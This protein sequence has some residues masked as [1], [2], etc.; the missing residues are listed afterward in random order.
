MNK[1]R[2]AWPFFLSLMVCSAQATQFIYVNQN[3]PA[4]SARNGASWGNAYW[5]LRDALGSP[6]AATASVNNPVEIWV[7]TGTYKPTSDT[8][9]SKSFAVPS[10]V[11]IRGGFAGTETSPSQRPGSGAWTVLSGDIGSPD[12]SAITA[13]NIGG[14]L[15][16]TALPPF[17]GESLYNS[18]NVL[19]CKGAANV[20]LDRLVITGGNANNTDAYDAPIYKLGDLEAMTW[21]NAGDANAFATGSPLVQPDSLTSGGGIFVSNY[22]SRPSSQPTLTLQNC[23][24]IHNSAENVGGALAAFEANLSV[25]GCSFL[26]NFAGKRGGA[27][28]GLNQFSSFEQCEFSNNSANDFGGAVFYNTLPSGK[29]VA[30]DLD[31]VHQAAVTG[32]IVSGISL[33]TS[34]ASYIWGHYDVGFINLSDI[35]SGL[36]DAYS[37]VG[38]AVTAGNFIGDVS[39]LLGGDPNSPAYKGYLEFSDLYAQYISPIGV[40]TLLSEGFGGSLGNV[41]HQSSFEDQQNSYAQGELQNFNVAPYSTMKDCSFVGNSVVGEGGAVVA[42]YDNVEFDRCWFLTNSA[43]TVAGAVALVGWNTP[44]MVSCAFSGNTAAHWYSTLDNTFHA[45]SQIINCTF[46][47]N[48]S[49]SSVALGCELGSEV[50]LYNSILWGNTNN[51]NPQGGAD[52]FVAT[53]NNISNNMLDTYNQAGPAQNDYIATMDMRFCTVQSFNSLPHGT[54]EFE[55]YPWNADPFLISVSEQYFQDADQYGFASLAGYCNLG[56]GIRPG[57]FTVYNGQN[58]EANNA[59]NPNLAGEGGVV[60][61]SVPLDLYDN[62]ADDEN[63]WS[64]NYNYAGT[65]PSVNEGT[66]YEGSYLDG[67]FSGV[68]TSAATPTRMPFEDIFG[69]GFSPFGAE[70][71]CVQF[72]GFEQQGLSD[73]GLNYYVRQGAPPHGDG[74]TWA[75]AFQNFDPLLQLGETMAWFPVWVAQ[76]S[77]QLSG[78]TETNAV[79]YGGFAGNETN[80]SQRNWAAH[81]TYLTGQLFCEGSIALDGFI[82]S[83]TVSADYPLLT[84]D[85]G[86]I[87]IVTNCLFVNNS[88]VY[89]SAIWWPGT[90]YLYNS[91]FIGNSSVWNGAVYAYDVTAQNCFFTSNSATQTYS[92]GGAIAFNSSVEAVNCIF[93]GNNA[94]YGSAIYGNTPNGGPWRLYN[95]TFYGNGPLALYMQ[96]DTP[97]L[98]APSGLI[99]PMPNPVN[100]LFWNDVSDGVAAQQFPG[101][102]SDP[103]FLDAVH[104]NFQLSAASP[105]IGAGLTNGLPGNFPQVDAAGQPRLFSGRLDMGAYEFQGFPQSPSALSTS[106]EV[107]GGFGNGVWGPAYTFQAALGNAVPSSL[108]WQVNIGNGLWTAI[109]NGGI[110]HGVDSTTLTVSGATAAMSG[111][112]YRLTGVANGVSFQLAPV[113][114]EASQGNNIVYVDGTRGYSYFTN[115][116]EG[117]GITPTWN[118]TSWATAFF[119]LDQAIAGARPGSEIWVR[120]GTYYPLGRLYYDYQY[121]TQMPAALSMAAGVRILGGFNG[122]ETADTQRNWHA[123]PTILS[124]DPNAA[125][126]IPGHYILNPSP[127]IFVNGPTV[128][129]AILDGFTLT[130]SSNGAV[131]NIGA[132]PTIQNC[133]FI[134]NTAS[135]GAAV[136]SSNGAILQMIDCVV[137]TNTVGE[138]ALYFADST[139]SLQNCILYDNAALQ[140]GG[141]IFATN[142]SLSLLNSAVLFNSAGDVSGGLFSFGGSNSIVNSIFWANSDGQSGTNIFSAQSGG[143]GAPGI[144]YSC[145]EGGTTNNNNLV[146]DPAFNL[147]ASNDFH[148][149]P[150]SPLIN[151]GNGA[152]A[153]SLGLDFDGNLRE[154]SGLVD[155]G[156]YQHQTTPTAPLF[157]AM[158]PYSV[159]VTNL[160]IY[161]ISVSNIGSPFGTAQWQVNTGS[162]FGPLTNT[163]SINYGTSLNGNTAAL[164]LY[165]TNLAANYNGLNGAQYRLV[166]AGLNVTS[167]PVVL[168]IRVPVLFYVNPLAAGPTHNGLTWAT[169]FTNLTQALTT[170]NQNVVVWVAQGSYSLPATV[171]WPIYGGFAG[172][173]LSL[174]QR[175]WTNHPT[176]LANG[177]SVTALVDGFIV[178]GGLQANYASPTIQNCALSGGGNMVYVNFGHPTVNQC[179]FSNASSGVYVAAGT[180]TVSNSTFTGGLANGVYLSYG[181]NAVVSTCLFSGISNG[182]VSWGTGGIA[183]AQCSV[184]RCIFQ[185]NTGA[186]LWDNDGT[187]VTVRDSLFVNNNGVSISHNGYGTATA[188]INCTIYSNQQPQGAITAQAYGSLT[189]TNCI[190]WN[191]HSSNWNYTLTQP[192]EFPVSFA[193]AAYSNSDVNEIFTQDPY[194]GDADAYSFTVNQAW[195]SYYN[196]LNLSYLDGYFPTGE[197]LAARSL[198]GTVANSCIEGLNY[199]SG[200]GNIGADPLLVGAGTNNFAPPSVSPVVDSGNSSVMI[201]GELDLAGNSRLFGAGVDMGAYE[202]QV[203]SAGVIAVTEGPQ[204]ETVTTPGVATFSAELAANSYASNYVWQI[205]VG[206]GWV[207]VVANGTFS[208]A[209]A[210][211]SS[212]LQMSPVDLSMNGDQVR[213]A[214][215]QISF[216]TAPATLTVLP[217]SLAGTVRGSVSAT[218]VLPPGIDAANYVWQINAGSGWSNLANGSIYSISYAGNTSTLLISGL[219]VALNGNQYRIAATNGSYVS[220]PDTLTVTV[221]QQ[222]YVSASAT[223]A[224]NGMSWA[225]AFTQLQ[226]GIAAAAPGQQIWVAAGTYSATNNAGDAAPWE[227]APGT[228]LYGGFQ[229]NETSLSQRNWLSNI[230]V[231]LPGPNA[232]AIS[233]QVLQADGTSVLDGFYLTG[234]ETQPVLVNVSVSPSIQNCTFAGNSAS[235]VSNVSSAGLFTNCL[236][237]SN[238]GPNSAYFQSG[239]A[240]ILANCIFSNNAA[241]NGGGGAVYIADGGGQFNACQFLT[242]SATGNGGAVLAPDDGGGLAM[243]QC[244]FSGNTSSSNGG[245][246]FVDGPVRLYLNYVTF[247]GNS[248]A[249]GGGLF[250]GPNLVQANLA[251]TLVADNYATNNGG[252]LNWQGQVSGNDFPLLIISCTF[253]DNSAGADGGGMYGNDPEIWNTIFWGNTSATSGLSVEFQQIYNPPFVA[254]SQ[255]TNRETEY[256]I[257][258]ENSIIQGLNLYNQTNNSQLFSVYNVG[259]NFS[260]DPDFVNAAAGQFELQ[261]YSPAISAGSAFDEPGL[262]LAGNPRIYGPVLDIGAYESQ[263]PVTSPFQVSSYPSS[264]TVCPGSYATFS[265]GTIATNFIWQV[266]NGSGFSDIVPS[267]L[268]S[269]SLTATSTVLTVNPATLALNGYQFQL[270]VPGYQYTTPAAALTVNP[271]PVAYVNPAATGNGSGADWANAFTNLQQAMGGNSCLQLWVAQGTYVI[272]T[273]S[274]G[275]TSFR[276]RQLLDMEGGFAGNETNLAARDYVHHPTILVPTN[277]QS[278]FFNDGTAGPIDHT[279]ILDGFI[280]TGGSVSPAMFN[281][282]ASPLIRNCV[283]TNN[284]TPS[285]Y[286]LGLSADAQATITNCWFV[287]NSASGILNNSSAPAILGCSFGQNAA[288][289]GAAIYNN[290][291]NGATAIIRCQFGTNSASEGGAVYNTAGSFLSIRD[292]LFSQNSVSYQGGAIS[293][294]GSLGMTN[295]TVADNRAGSAGGGLWVASGGSLTVANSIFWGNA[296]NGSDTSTSLAQIN[297][298]AG[299]ALFSSL[300]TSMVEGSSYNPLFVNEPGGDYHL[301]SDSPALDVASVASVPGDD[302]DLDGNP[303]VARSSVDLGAYEYQGAAAAPANISLLPQSADACASNTVLFTVAAPAT[304]GFAYVWQEQSGAE[305]TTLS[306]N[307][308][309]AISTSGGTGTLSISNVPMALNGSSYRVLAQ[310]NSITVTSAVFTLDVTPRS[311][312]YVNSQAARGGNGS[313]WSNAFANLADAFGS[314]NC[315]DIWIAAGTYAVTND[316]NGSTATPSLQEGMRLFGGFA[317]TETSLAQRNPAANPTILMA[318]SAA[319]A[320]EA[321]GGVD[322]ATV[323]DGLTFTGG[324]NTPGFLVSASSPLIQNCVFTGNS[325]GAIASQ[326]GASPTVVNCSFTNNAGSAAAS[327][328]AASPSFVN[329]VFAGNQSP[330]GQNGGAIDAESGSSVSLAQ[331]IFSNNATGAAGGALYLNQSAAL[332]AS[333]LIVNN[334]ANTG[335][336]IA[337]SGATLVLVNDTVAQNSAS[338]GGG[339]SISGAACVTNSIL[340]N[341]GP[342]ESSQLSG[343]AIVANSCIEGLNQFAGN[344]NIP[345]DPLFVNAAGN[346]F[347]LQSGSPCVDTG[348]N[349]DA[350][351]GPDLGGAPRIQGFSVDMGAYESSGVGNYIEITQQPVSQTV[352]QGNAVSFAAAGPANFGT[353][354]NWQVNEGGGFVALPQSSGYSV[355]ASD[356]T[357][358]L[359]VSNPLPGMSGYQYRAQIG[360]L[361]LYSSSATLSVLPHSIIYVNSTASGNG[362]GTNWA[363]AM[364][365][366]DGA[367]A[368]AGPCVDVWVAGGTYA[369]AE[370][371]GG[372]GFTVNPST[373]VYGGFAGTE[374]NLSQRN[375]TSHPTFLISSGQTNVIQSLSSNVGGFATVLDGFTIT[376]STGAGFYVQ[377]GNPTVQNCTFTSNSGPAVAN[378]GGAPFIQNCVFVSNLFTAIVNENGG[379]LTVTNTQFLSNHSPAQGGAIFSQDASMSIYRS[380]FTGNTGADGG[381]ICDSA[382]CPAVTLDHCI[383]AGNSATDEGGA[384][385]NGQNCALSVVNCLIDSNAASYG[386]G[387]ANYAQLSVLSTTIYGNDSTQGGGGFYGPQGSAGFTNSILWSN[388]LALSQAEGAFATGFSIIQGQTNLGAGGL[389]FDPQFVNPAAGNFNLEPY[390][391][392]IGAGS[393]AAASGIV[394]DLSFQPR[395]AAWGLDVGAYESSSGPRSNPVE[396][397][398]SPAGQSACSEHSDAVFTYTAATNLSFAWEVYPAYGWQAIQPNPNGVAGDFGETYY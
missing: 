380:L 248:A 129:N 82:V 327:A 330:R 190:L 7:A 22:Y 152:A 355:S 230:C 47:G 171:N 253:A 134:S 156:P 98:S 284:L 148:L 43:S 291:T 120:S 142:S 228:T 15:A 326:A 196:W 89:A 238:L 200:N 119:S 27:F 115:E 387:L 340:W 223:G 18:Y 224:A 175:S 308:L 335:G 392:A 247:T 217:G 113:G 161:N 378:V 383:L 188:V 176:I 131:V 258:I 165:L 35:P 162:G 146:T 234:G 99:G 342:G 222:V 93:N 242:N 390:S 303:R 118:G 167:P 31:P 273:G 107:G 84:S 263:S 74:L 250:A 4:T 42:Q 164:T 295:C 356:A 235:A 182:I 94:H 9:R 268:Y 108:Q 86:T 214:A 170:T 301:N 125:G 56:Q 183:S 294:Y 41:L 336:A 52:L 216:A 256:L 83:N 370:A 381:A 272:P 137:T 72:Q 80:L 243:P 389:A 279:A 226:D 329:C 332:V 153:S 311:V 180:A 391:P 33:F 320:L 100:C 201:P 79:F 199:F 133:L 304:N 181:A 236:F 172:N 364:P 269:V 91:S 127:S 69:Q 20:M 299:S 12:G 177:A 2:L 5:E 358:T 325:D 160:G 231:L 373:A 139:G 289:E 61:H 197:F 384:V 345:Y 96:A 375:L 324:V 116:I 393:L 298:A 77:Y 53:V 3:A 287:N 306:P 339:I 290:S 38:L 331:C 102:D 81:P 68:D 322:N 360:S 398:V 138:G 359:V 227:L 338:S 300:T 354:F 314:G 296:V 70:R 366:L 225:N 76:G 221:P 143:S 51:T 34:S 257:F 262:D 158:L 166:A 112:Q 90:L 144:F 135:A 376:S 66:H 195:Q 55:I 282:N 219:T 212:I 186:G 193:A 30:Q 1:A 191:N 239:S 155:V 252:G 363:N 173:E 21:A 28:G 185:G 141:A 264:E 23:I 315:S 48:S 348:L 275:T 67:F 249:N 39:I 73:A 280:L 189:V 208:V 24:L 310:G 371:G 124:S 346:V 10:W 210:L 11:T 192:T 106:V 251:S 150:S 157:S 203:P 215:P 45:R 259:G 46:V 240:P 343:N 37:L 266:N 353:N 147:T 64:Y 244:V 213:L 377:Q 174:A 397:S 63:L 85:G 293:D 111:Y 154:T 103:L 365:G 6:G 350:P 286:N 140:N 19:T 58:N 292:S 312:I 71:G 278:I 271:S 209:N 309:Y 255:V 229:G 184:S 349:T 145:I 168:F 352:C 316:L 97:F 60:P 149:S 204:S 114:L 207:N 178:Q 205:N 198:Y 54:E 169:A 313:S 62:W 277:G 110:Y 374:T 288:G 13:A 44:R 302:L 136:V 385:Y 117:V 206:S 104:G 347:T 49:P 163:P 126:L 75:T 305:F 396:I 362:T 36:M 121:E 246:L 78:I 218:A 8:V 88:A 388:G 333:C 254:D 361:S 321:V 369:P 179:I 265:L 351:A 367:L 109:A 341:N 323:V 29:T 307:A 194:N 57:A 40:I 395:V 151:A 65:L 386:G 25:T 276:M 241:T 128:T 274:N 105:A 344:N 101:T 382:N 317:G 14:I 17:H 132:N 297:G 95:D 123:N 368:S 281:I 87:G 122:T 334:S 270:R 211:N 159:S 337:G 394:T 283:F 285:I 59:I 32:A 357:S 50:D 261:P 245:A 379:S 319:P 260:L 237:I 232:P 26:D 92:E 202:L 267:L 328:L 187:V 220:L 372:A 16:G 318:A 233:N 130:A